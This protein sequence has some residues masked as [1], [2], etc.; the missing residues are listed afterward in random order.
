ML[1][2]SWNTWQRLRATLAAVALVAS[3]IL[4]GASLARADAVVDWND[5]TAQAYATSITAG[6]PRLVGI[7]DF[8]MVHA[9]VHDAVQ[10]IDK[11]FKPYHVV[12]PGASGSPIA[13]AIQ[14]A[15]DVLLNL[16]P[17]QA[18]F[19]DTAYHDSLTKYSLAKTDPGVIVGQQAAAGILALRANDGRLPPD[20]PPFT[21]GTNPGVWRPTVSSLPGPPPTLSPGGAPWLATVTPF[22][23]RAPTQFRAA[24][25]HKLSSKRY[26]EEYNEVKA[27]GALQSSTR[28]AA[29]TDIAYFY[30]DNTFL[31]WN[32]GLRSIATTKVT[33]IGDS[34]R[35][36]ALANLATA[37]AV[38][39]AWDSK[40]HYVFWR[41]VTAIQEG[42]NDGNAR[43]AGDPTWQPL[44]NT[45]N[46]PDHTSGANV[47]AAAMT[48][49]LALF[50][51]TDAMPLSLTSN[52]PPVVQKTRTY[53]RFSDAT[54]DVV[55]A[56]IY[57]GIHFR[58][59]DVDG[60]TQG[61]RVA[62]WAF[63]HVLRP[64]KR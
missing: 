47:C 8:A 20:P 21:G 54:E 26:A 32:R 59:P 60:R 15:H 44:I 28:S 52:N 16:F 53:S 56:R 4:S 30:A 51:G 13:A 57:A 49:T 1:S 10:A 25:P 46:Y 35:L 6:R 17:T 42:A 2:L 3:T 43:T 23:L 50:F 27:L 7:I 12:I 48:R 19:L 33:K 63:K 55:N 29:Q 38:I 24:P 41:P 40:Y 62:E 9:A 18:A 37:D 39:T 31:L 14:A 36:F 11:R 58:K 22:T 64:I 61:R 5:I 34:A 45:P